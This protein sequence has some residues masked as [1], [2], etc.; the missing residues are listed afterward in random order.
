MKQLDSIKWRFGG[1]MYS[2]N[3]FLE[4][5]AKSSQT[6]EGLK[7]EEY[8]VHNINM[9]IKDPNNLFENLYILKEL[10]NSL[11]LHINAVLDHVFDSEKIIDQFHVGNHLCFKC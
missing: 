1:N 8:F 11:R 2:N 4:N 3:D 6:Y 5:T 9:F 7:F 10:S